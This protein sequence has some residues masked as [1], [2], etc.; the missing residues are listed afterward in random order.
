[1]IEIAHEGVQQGRDTP[2]YRTLPAFRS[3]ISQ[4]PLLSI[5]LKTRL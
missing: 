3:F 5:L 4:L 2:A 1:M